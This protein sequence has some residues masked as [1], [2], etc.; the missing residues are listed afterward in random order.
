MMDMFKRLCIKWMKRKHQRMLKQYMLLEVDKR[1]CIEKVNR[2]R[3]FLE[4][5]GFSTFS[6][7]EAVYALDQ[8]S[9]KTEK[10]KDKRARMHNFIKMHLKRTR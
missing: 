7:N 6:A 8:V 1:R 10:L 2:H 4:S 5:Y 3:A 9:I